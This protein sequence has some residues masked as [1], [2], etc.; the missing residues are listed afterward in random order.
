[1]RHMPASVVSLYLLGEPVGSTL[2]AFVFLREVPSMLTLFGSA[3][4]LLG[5]AWVT[6]ATGSE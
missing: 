6:R 2:L 5:L 3:L 4:V 1:L